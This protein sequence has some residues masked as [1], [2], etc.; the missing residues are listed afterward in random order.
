M[1]ITHTNKQLSHL[2]D[3]ESARVESILHLGCMISDCDACPQSLRDFLEDDIFF[4]K[5]EIIPG[6]DDSIKQ[7]LKDHDL[8]V[9][10][11]WAHE[12]GRLGFLVKIATP[13]MTHHGAAAIYSWARYRTH[14]F[15]A[16]TFQD[17][18]ELGLEWVE[19]CRVAEKSTTVQ[20]EEQ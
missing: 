11:S 12:Q 20:D 9:F 17:A 2:L 15:Y 13:V 7:S 10:C 6:M 19:T 18:I 3:N 8:Y 4:E 16:E 14:W 1:K 5:D